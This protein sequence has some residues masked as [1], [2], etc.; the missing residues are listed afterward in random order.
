M[1]TPRH[2]LVVE[3]NVLVS[4]ALSLLLGESGYT[5]TV[6]RTLADA[7]RTSGES[8][9]DVVLLDL[10]LADGDGLQLLDTLR[11]RE[12]RPPIVFALTGRDDPE[13][14]ARCLA[15]GCADVLVKPV[16]ISELL[17]RVAA[18]AP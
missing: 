3:D 6:A 13:T 11:D 15:K 18:S 16:P 4:D 7:E 17:R 1:I 14:R 9:V 5:V 12:T 2:V 10:G 8:K